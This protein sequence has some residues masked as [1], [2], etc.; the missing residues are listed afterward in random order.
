MTST[1]TQSYHPCSA[2]VI[3]CFCLFLVCVCVFQNLYRRKPGAFLNCARLPE[4]MEKNRYRDVLP[5]ESIL[6]S[7]LVFHPAVNLPPLGLLKSLS[8]HSCHTLPSCYCLQMTPPGCCCRARRTTS[9]PATSRCASL[10]PTFFPSSSLCLTAGP[11]PP[12]DGAPGVRRASALRGGSGP[13]A[14]DLR[15]LLAECVG[16][17]GTHHHHA[18]HPDREGTGTHAL[19][20]HT[21]HHRC[22]TL[23]R[24]PILARSV[25]TVGLRGNTNSK[26]WPADTIEDTYR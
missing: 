8:C 14:A 22:Q 21:L 17:A 6:P 2:T 26:S 11:R 9:T 19:H 23:V 1:L 3:L 13:P 25:T 5:C 24:G 10:T 4:N 7:R 20:A 15:S 18:D 16:A 12:P